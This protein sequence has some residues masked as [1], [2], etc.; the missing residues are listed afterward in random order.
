MSIAA[1]ILRLRE[2]YE[3]SFR[4]KCQILTPRGD[5]SGSSG[6]LAYDDPVPQGYVPSEEEYVCDYMPTIEK[7][8]GNLVQFA[9]NQATICLPITV[10]VTSAD[11]IRLTQ[12]PVGDALS[13]D[14]TIE[15]APSNELSCFWKLSCKLVGGTT[16]W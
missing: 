4:W 14:F 8:V 9:L 13:I 6:D 2:H 12:D 5:D 10:A 7:Q 16:Q 15:G 1:D 11:R 3:A